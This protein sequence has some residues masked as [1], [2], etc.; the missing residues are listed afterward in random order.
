MSIVEKISH[1][2]EILIYEPLIEETSFKGTRVD[3]DLQNFKTPSD[4]II[5]NR[6]HDELSD[7]SDKVFTRDL[8]NIN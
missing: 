3:N 7:V 4:L 6:F 5:A 8:F 1:S 2:K